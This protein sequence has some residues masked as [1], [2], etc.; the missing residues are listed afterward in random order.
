MQGVLLMLLEDDSMAV[1]RTCIETISHFA[2]RCTSTRQ[3]TLRL[4][5]DMLNDEIDEV[6]I[7]ALEGISSFN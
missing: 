6:R 2:Q 5:I 1:R 7:K 4:L 3:T